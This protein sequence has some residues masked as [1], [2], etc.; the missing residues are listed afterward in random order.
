MFDLHGRGVDGA[1]IRG[2]RLLEATYYLDMAALWNLTVVHAERSDVPLSPPAE[3]K[4]FYALCRATLA[5]AIYFLEA[6][7]NGVAFDYLAEHEDE[8]SAD[9]R[10]ALQERDVKTKLPRRLSLYQKVLRYQRIA[11]GKEHA[12]IQPSNCPELAFLLRVAEDSR[13]PLAHPAPHLHPDTGIAEKEFAIFKVDIDMVRATVD[14]AI[15][16]VRKFE[17]LLH[18]DL[19]R[20]P[21]LID[22]DPTGRFPPQA[23][24]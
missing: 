14:S 18:G 9:D 23:V 22:R 10:S 11:L 20:V 8:L 5:T 16:V 13:N 15:V 24:D 12:P 3:L 21:W 1:P 6:Y 17:E 2:W 7:F 19:K 4:T